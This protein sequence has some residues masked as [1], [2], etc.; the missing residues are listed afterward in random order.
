MPV[1]PS[2]PS[3]ISQVPKVESMPLDLQGPPAQRANSIEPIQPTTPAPPTHSSQP[4]AIQQNISNGN[5]NRK[6][7]SKAKNKNSK[8]PKILILVTLLMIGGVLGTYLK[9]FSGTRS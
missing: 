6:Q 7:V 5:P 8:L 4:N 1:S 3:P 9:V 2:G